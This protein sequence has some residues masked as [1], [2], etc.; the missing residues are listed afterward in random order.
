VDVNRGKRSCHLDLRQE[1]DL[2]R[3]KNLV[4]EADVFVQSYRPASLSE[5]GLGPEQLA[6]IRP[7]I[8]CTSLAAYGWTGPWALRRGYDSLVQTATGFNVDEAEAAGE[9][10]PKEFPC[11]ALDHASG[12]LMALGTLTALGRRA[13]EGGSWQ[14]KVSLARTGLWLRS[15]GRLEHGFE[16]A[17]PTIDGV[18][19][20][21]EASLSGFGRLDAIRHSAI[22]SETPAG[23][24]RSSVAPGTDL[25]VWTGATERL[26]SP[27]I[28]E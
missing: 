12:Y 13:D 11:Q 24:R 27:Q 16:A 22:L 9:P 20:L 7:G 18:S 1:L 8:V 17:N 10:E 23:F 5:R 14:V 3:L 25:P 6:A 19:D 28:R 2:A 26:R 21:L 15:L 4:G